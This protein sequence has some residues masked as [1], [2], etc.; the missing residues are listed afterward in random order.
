MNI[1]DYAVRALLGGVISIGLTSCSKDIIVSPDQPAVTKRSSDELTDNDLSK[2]D[3]LTDNS[4]LESKLDTS[5][6][7]PIPEPKL[8]EIDLSV[9]DNI[10]TPLFFEP[11]YRFDPNKVDLPP[12]S[13]VSGWEGYLSA[14]LGIENQYYPKGNEYKGTPGTIAFHLGRN[15]TKSQYDEPGIIFPNIGFA[16]N[17]NKSRYPFGNYGEGYLGLIARF[18]LSEVSQLLKKSPLINLDLRYVYREPFNPGETGTAPRSSYLGL[19]SENFFWANVNYQGTKRV[20]TSDLQI[21]TM[22]GLTYDGSTDNLIFNM[23]NFF[24]YTLFSASPAKVNNPDKEGVRADF[25]IGDE[26]D[27]DQNN[28]PWRRFIKPSIGL[29]FRRV[30]DK[31]GIFSKLPLTFMIKGYYQIPFDDTGDRIEKPY[32]GPGFFIGFLYG[33]PCDSYPN[34]MESGNPLKPY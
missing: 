11:K 22:L 27:Y 21:E 10:K 5:G 13:A 9:P 28:E 14:L 12:T 29:R 26:I 4:D 3:G 30:Q 23:S 18:R 24:L 17:V 32:K 33:G 34:I 15:L 16:A 19:E 31:K 8:S 25:F 20:K 7:D 2:I 6:A 1:K